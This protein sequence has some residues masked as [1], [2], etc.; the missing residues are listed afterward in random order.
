MGI[1]IGEAM[2]QFIMVIITAIILG[3]QLCNLFTDITGLAWPYM[4]VLI[5]LFIINVLLFLSDYY[6]P[7]IKALTNIGG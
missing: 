1:Y 2:P 4:K 7:L 3:W 5:L 6:D